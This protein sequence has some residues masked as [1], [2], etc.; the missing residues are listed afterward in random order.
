MIRNWRAGAH[1][2]LSL[3]VGVLSCCGVSSCA[4]T[5]RDFVKAKV[6]ALNADDYLGVKVSVKGRVV[7]EGPA[8]AWF[9]MEDETGRV[10]VS[11]ERLARRIRCSKG[12]EAAAEG[13]LRRV[14]GAE[15]LYF[16]MESL[17]H[18]RP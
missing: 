6:F 11:S 17:L 4:K 3:I 12:S 14:P 13:T 18:C 9:E 15:G 8:S 1:R 7:R 10:L 5:E 2:W 16:S